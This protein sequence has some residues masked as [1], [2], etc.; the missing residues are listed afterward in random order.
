MYLNAITK[1]IA[2]RPLWPDFKLDKSMVFRMSTHDC[3]HSQNH[4]ITE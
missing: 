4:R 1:R 3:S 2:S